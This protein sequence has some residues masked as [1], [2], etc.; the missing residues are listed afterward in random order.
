[1]SD[2]TTDPRRPLDCPKCGTFTEK[3][4]LFWREYVEGFGRLNAMCQYCGYE[5]QRDTVDSQKV[6]P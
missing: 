2:P 4:K 6:Q 1:V 3:P 5:Q